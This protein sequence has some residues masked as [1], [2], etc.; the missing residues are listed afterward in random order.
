MA[1]DYPLSTR[2]DTLKKSQYILYTYA[3]KLDGKHVLI[4][5]GLQF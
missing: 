1:F 3:N 5:L 4:R 2:A